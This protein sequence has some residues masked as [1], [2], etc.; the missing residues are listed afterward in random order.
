MKRL[1]AAK[2]GGMVTKVNPE[3]ET[4]F[5]IPNHKEYFPEPEAE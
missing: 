3:H 5:Y 2:R 1:R 4:S